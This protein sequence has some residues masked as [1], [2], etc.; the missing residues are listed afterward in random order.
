MND[1]RN[2]LLQTFRDFVKICEGNNLK[3]YAA[4]GTVL[5]AVRHNGFIPW[6]DDIDVYMPRKDY[7]ALYKICNNENNNYCVCDYRDDNYYLF[8]PKFINKKTTLIQNKNYRFVQGVYVDI[9]VL[10]NYIEDTAD[11]NCIIKEYAKQYLNLAGSLNYSSMKEFLS[12]LSHGHLRSVW[13][14]IKN[15]Y[16]HGNYEN[17]RSRI[18]KLHQKIDSVVGNNRI[19]SYSVNPLWFVCYDKDWFGDGVRMTFEDME[20]V[21]P[22]KYHEYL[23]G[24]YGEYMKYPPVNEQKPKHDYIYL[25]LNERLDFNVAISKVIDSK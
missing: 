5:G 1:F 20:V 17:Y 23:V 21:L 4:Y 10:D 22:I 15:I 8:F 16:R 7:E 24:Q 2:L 11:R 13:T 14:I 6:D 19:C 25:N 9:F 3:Y 18:S 12:L